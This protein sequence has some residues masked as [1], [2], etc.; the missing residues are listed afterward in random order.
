MAHLAPLSISVHGL[1]LH[2]NGGTIMVGPYFQHI[3]IT[4]RQILMNAVGRSPRQYFMFLNCSFLVCSLL[5]CLQSPIQRICA[6]YTCTYFYRSALFALVPCKPK[7]K[8]LCYST[9]KLSGLFRL[10]TLKSEIYSDIQVGS[11]PIL[12]KLEG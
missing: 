2:R 1:H 6:W 4:E 5:Y 10:H 11:A 12:H 3:S 9:G 7:K 8:S